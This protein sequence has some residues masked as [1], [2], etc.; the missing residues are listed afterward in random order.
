MASEGPSLNPTEGFGN[1]AYGCIK[2][3]SG[4]AKVDCPSVILNC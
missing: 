1:E 4:I 3:V 2:A